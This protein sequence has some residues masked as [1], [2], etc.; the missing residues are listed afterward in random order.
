MLSWSGHH[1]GA[2][3]DLAAVATGRGAS[4]IPLGAELSAFA[5]A[6]ANLGGDR[7]AMKA[8]R[9]LLLAR[10][11]HAFMIDTAAV[12]ANFQMMTRLAD[13]T[14]AR[15]PTERLDAAAATIDAMHAAAMTSRR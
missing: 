4:G 10:T 6:A 8:A 9:D 14:G 3:V 15:Y 2:E 11:D 12:A 13:A 5:S 1:T 7:D